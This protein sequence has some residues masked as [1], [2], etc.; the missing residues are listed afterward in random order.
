MLNKRQLN[1]NKKIINLYY[2]TLDELIDFDIELKEIERV[3][4]NTSQ[5]RAGSEISGYPARCFCVWKL[6]FIIEKINACV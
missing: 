5:Q 1:L 2:L 4:E 6:K 3:I